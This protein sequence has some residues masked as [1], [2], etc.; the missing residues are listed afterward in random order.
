MLKNA[1]ESANYY[2]N[3]S[4]H[5]YNVQYSY[6]KR[7]IS[8]DAGFGASTMAVIHHAGL[9]FYRIFCNCSDNTAKT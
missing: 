6:E 4:K 2:L 7:L 8:V 5:K 1:I 9:C 3:M